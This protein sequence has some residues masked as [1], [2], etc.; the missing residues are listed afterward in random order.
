[1]DTRFEL[2]IG[3]DIA[4]IPAVSDRLEEA[5]LANGFSAEDILDTQLA[6]EE[7]ITNVILHGY[8][9]P[10]EPI[11]VFCHISRNRMEVQ[12][13]DTAP[14]FDP[15]SVPEPDLGGSVEDRSIG[16]LGVYLIRQVMD[17]VSYRYENG[18]NILL[19][20]KRRRG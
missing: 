15:L 7:A 14:P 9:K 4:E 10:G 1:M 17:D 18:R 20:S 19:L 12:V 16:G 11:V 13:A 8:R 6:V 5:L 3:S 2:T